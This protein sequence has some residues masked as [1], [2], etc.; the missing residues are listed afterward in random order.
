VAEARELLRFTGDTE[1]E[2]LDSVGLPGDD[3]C[4]MQITQQLR[5]VI[6]VII[7]FFVIVFVII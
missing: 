6:F 5:S 2:M 7:Y 3:G 1:E 4:C